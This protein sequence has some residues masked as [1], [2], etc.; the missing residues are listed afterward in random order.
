LRSFEQFDMVAPMTD[1]APEGEMKK[2]SLGQAIDA[3]TDALGAFEARDQQTIL[4]AVYDHLK[5]SGPTG[6]A[7][8]G[9]ASGMH[10]ASTPESPP[11]SVRPP[12]GGDFAGMDIRS[13]KESKAPN[14]ARQMACVVAYYLS[15]I[16][17]G[18][19]KS[20]VVTNALLDKYFKQARFP[21][22]KAFEQVLP[23][24]KSAGYF[25]GAGRGEYRLNRVGYNL[26]AHQLPP[27]AKA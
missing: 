11:A 15:E 19:E 5:I 23:D 8:A 27:K 16:A 9:P 4:R 1:K 10:A 17:E 12:A 14:S 24:A 2:M 20:E 18:E 25:E 3:V 21:M 22:P 26:V 6:P 7:P 13:F